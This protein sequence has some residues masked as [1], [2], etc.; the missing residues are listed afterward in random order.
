[1]KEKDLNILKVAGKSSV[2]SVA[3]S[4]VKSLEDGKRVELHGIGA[5]AISQITKAVASASGIMATKG[6]ELLIKIGF[7]S[8]IIEDKEMTMM[9]FKVIIN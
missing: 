2:S 8:T 4:I 3:G 5:S 1:M 6:S 7:S 9:I